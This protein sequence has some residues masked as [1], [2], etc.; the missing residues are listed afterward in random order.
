MAQP[1]GG[2]DYPRNQPEFNEFFPSDRACL[3]YL[4]HLRWGEGFSCPSC[5]HDE[6]WLRKDGLYQCCQCRRKTSPTAG[7]IFDKTRFGLQIW[8]AAIWHVTSQKD[9]ASA[10]GLQRVLGIGSYE[11]AWAWLHK[12]RRAMVP[13]SGQL[14]GQVEVDESF[15]GG[16]EAGVR[17]RLTKKKA[18]VIIAVE[19]WRND[20]SGRVRM[21]V[22]PDFKAST[23]CGF[24]QEVVEPGSTVITDG[25]PAYNRLP[26]LGYDHVSINIKGSGKQA[27]EL[28]P[29]VHRVAALLKRWLL[30]THQGGGAL[31]HVDY[32]LD[33]FSFRWNRRSSKHRGL[34][35]YR[36]V[37]QAAQTGPQPYEELLSPDAR[38][39]RQDQV[40]RATAKRKLGKTGPVITQAQRRAKRPGGRS[41]RLADPI[42]RRRPTVKGRRG[43]GKGS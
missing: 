29:V 14:R 7:T 15:V 4:A 23:L 27:H 17:G 12:L 5:A 25:L 24:V 31:S 42:T 11:T 40:R 33:E 16:F 1:V 39:R 37:Q 32:Y 43:L 30:S 22:I 13:T 38:K 19:K 9:G 18:R 36:L 8:F 21:R 28:M 20:R 6:Y 41:N 10:L 2:R 3:S 26:S 35:F 34:L